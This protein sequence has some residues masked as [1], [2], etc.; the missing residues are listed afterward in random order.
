M[1]KVHVVSRLL[2]RRAYYAEPLMEESVVKVFDDYQKVIDYICDAV[3]KDHKYLD[4]SQKDLTYWR[5]HKPNPD[6]FKEGFK[7]KSTEYSDIHYFEYT[8]YKFRSYDVE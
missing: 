8:G 5:K 6:N 3:K 1:G 2:Y 7:I 4:N